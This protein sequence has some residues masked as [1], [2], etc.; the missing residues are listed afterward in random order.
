MNRRQGRRRL[1]TGKQSGGTRRQEDGISDQVMSPR[2]IP[3]S[4]PGL[5]PRKAVN[6]REVGLILERKMASIKTVK[7]Y[8]TYSTNELVSTSGGV[9]DITIIPQGVS[10]LARVADTIFVQRVDCRIN[11][12]TANID[13]INLVRL[14]FF[15]WRVDS[16]LA[17]PT[18]ADLLSFVGT[19][20][21][22][23]GNFNFENRAMYGVWKDITFNMSG[24]ATNP[25]KNSQHYLEFSERMDNKRIDF[26]LGATSGTGKIYFAEMSDSDAVPYPV[27]LSNFR[28]WFMDE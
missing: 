3:R 27:R 22:V 10:Q 12:N 5:N 6:A 28:V 16:A 24:T 21:L 7:Y 17:A 4:G 25:T 18:V 23:Y 1:N 9:V 8:D 26:N 19:T 2:P 13:I 14:I 11:V 20:P 15:N